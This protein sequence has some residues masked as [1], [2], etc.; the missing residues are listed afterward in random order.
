MTSNRRMVTR[1]SRIVFLLS[2]LVSGVNRYYTAR[3]HKA[4]IRLP[5]ASSDVSRRVAHHQHW[6]RRDTLV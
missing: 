3:G 1:G 6:E 5:G 4:F 2:W